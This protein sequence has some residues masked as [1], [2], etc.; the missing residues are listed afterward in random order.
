MAEN[1]IKCENLTYSYGS[2]KAIDGVSF[3]IDRG[4]YLCILGENGTGKSTLVKLLLGLIKQDTGTITYNG[5][6]NTEI[7]YLPQTT[8]T[9]AM[10]PAS[11]KEVVLQ[12]R[13]NKLGRKFFYSSED[14]KA[15]D[16]MKRKAAWKRCSFFRTAALYQ[17]ITLNSYRTRQMT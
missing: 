17:S 1:Y 16:E 12:G 8:E 4:D 14:K 2:K 11:V 9:E 7:G 10:F 6:N 13:C 5:I 15:A 3:E